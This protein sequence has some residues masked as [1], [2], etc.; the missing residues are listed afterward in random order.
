[1]ED[2]ILAIDQGTS[3]TKALLMNVRGEVV[4]QGLA[5]L[6]TT[7]FP[8]GHVEQDPLALMQSVENAV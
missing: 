7:Y 2:L 8:N 4:A 6:E 3:S 5:N 1:M